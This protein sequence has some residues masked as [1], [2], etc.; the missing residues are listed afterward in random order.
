MGAGRTR[1]GTIE[2]GGLARED[3]ETLVD[4]LLADLG[5]S[6]DLR[7]DVL[8]KAEGN[9]LFVEETV[10]MLAEGA[11][12]LAPI[13]D[14]VQALIAA[15]IDGLP[16]PAKL[17]LQR[18]GVVGRVF[19]RGALATLS[20]SGDDVDAALEELLR[21]DFVLREPHSSISGEEAFRFK[22]ILIREVAYGV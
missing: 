1:G 5:L 12:G 3:A 14:T 16:R 17:A 20:A 13:P 11:D 18:A 6:S 21:R 10:R 4:V 19:W 2:L 9:P 22:H 15:R 7:A 8:D